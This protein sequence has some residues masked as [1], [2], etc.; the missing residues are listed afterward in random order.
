MTL[1]KCYPPDA[2]HLLTNSRPIISAEILGYFLFSFIDNSDGQLS[3][4]LLK[5]HIVLLE[6]TISSS[7]CKFP[8]LR[9]FRNHRDGDHKRHLRRPEM[10]PGGRCFV[11]PRFNTSFI[12]SGLPAE[13]YLRFTVA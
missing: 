10:M 11:R 4:F 8:Y 3:L 6:G 5:T 7:F 9:P 12:M 1:L 13:L 2:T